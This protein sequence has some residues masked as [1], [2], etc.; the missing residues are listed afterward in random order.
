MSPAQK[1][2]VFMHICKSDENKK[3]QINREFEKLV[4]SIIHIK[5]NTEEAFKTANTIKGE[6]FIRSLIKSADIICGTKAITNGILF[7]FAVYFF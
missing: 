5:K 7:F 2:K 3:L 4:L 6:H 1:V